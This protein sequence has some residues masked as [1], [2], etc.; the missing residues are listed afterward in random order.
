MITDYHKSFVLCYVLHYSFC[1][2]PPTAIQLTHSRCLA[3]I[4]WWA[5][6]DSNQASYKHLIYS[7][8]RYLLRNTDPYRRFFVWLTANHDQCATTLRS[9]PRATTRSLKDGRL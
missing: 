6:L 3:V 4:A 5:A 2:G 9:Y 7:Q 8:D 1:R